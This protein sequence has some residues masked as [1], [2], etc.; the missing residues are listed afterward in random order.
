MTFKKI[1]MNQLIKSNLLKISDA[2]LIEIKIILS[3]AG[4]TKYTDEQ[5]NKIYVLLKAIEIVFGF[6]LRDLKSGRRGEKL[7]Y[8]RRV[9]FYYFKN[10]LPGI[11]LRKLAKTISKDSATVRYDLIM[12][13]NDF[14]SINIKFKKYVEWIE[15]IIYN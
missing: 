4:I 9:W 10:I 3:A 14:S 11:S 13:K 15:K 6:T 1:N 7:S 5:I 2:A 8:S 12:F